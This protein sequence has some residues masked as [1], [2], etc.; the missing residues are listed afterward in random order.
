M[1]FI[2]KQAIFALLFIFIQSAFVF[3][4]KKSEEEVKV[5][6]ENAAKALKEIENDFSLREYLPEILSEAKKYLELAKDSLDDNERDWASYYARLSS[7]TSSTALYR[8]KTDFL[9]WK[10]M[11]EEIRFWKNLAVSEDKEKLYQLKVEQLKKELLSA[12]IE[13][14]MANAGLEKSG[15]VFTFMLKDSEIFIKGTFAI[16]DAGKIPL[17]KVIEILSLISKAKITIE[18][19]TS[20]S[21]KENLSNIKANS[22]KDYLVRLGGIYSESISIVGYGNQKPIVMNEKVVYGPA[23]DRIVI[24]F[25]IPKEEK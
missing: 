22:V 13:F 10:K 3:A 11:E 7:I 12:R 17:D 19:H 4:D 1:L 21:D 24:Y 25:E 18:G 20:R 6:I 16:S 15:K 9:K 5:E 23:N 8:A 2:K 14:A